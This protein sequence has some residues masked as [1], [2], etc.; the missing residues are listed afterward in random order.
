MCWELWD[1]HSLFM[2]WYLFIFIIA[3]FFSSMTINKLSLYIYVIRFLVQNAR[4]LLM[5]YWVVWASLTFFL[6]KTIK[7]GVLERIY[8]SKSKKWNKFSSK[9]KK[10]IGKECHECIFDGPNE[11]FG[12][13]GASW[14]RLKMISTLAFKTLFNQG[15]KT[16]QLINHSTHFC[17][18][19]Y[20]YGLLNST[21]EKSRKRWNI[22]YIMV[23][24]T[25]ISLATLVILV[26]FFLI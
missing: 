13:I 24:E 4:R 3:L 7:F 25:L 17:G 19:N 9:Y 14:C 18:F 11:L 15:K 8:A 12:F 22:I 1:A 10:K 20:W 21:C 23:N 2:L 6:V 26:N 16:I 5:R